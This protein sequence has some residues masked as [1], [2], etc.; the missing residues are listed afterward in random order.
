[1]CNINIGG[2]LQPYWMLAV[3]CTYE[4]DAEAAEEG[5]GAAL[6]HQR[7]AGGAHAA[8]RGVHRQPQPQG[9]QRVR[10]LRAPQR[11][12]TSVRVRNEP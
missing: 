5:G 9:I 4:G 10:Q 2:A 7:Y 8:Q 11:A 6:P 3:I 1:M 12:T